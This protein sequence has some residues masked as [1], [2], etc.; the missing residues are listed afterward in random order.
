M[1]EDEIEFD[2]NELNE[3]IFLSDMKDKSLQEFISDKIKNAILFV[4]RKERSEKIKKIFE[5]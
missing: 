1:K 5:K 3:P 2:T 4:K